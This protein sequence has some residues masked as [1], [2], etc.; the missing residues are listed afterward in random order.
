MKSEYLKR[1]KVDSKGRLHGELIMIEILQ[2]MTSENKTERKTA[3]GII[4]TDTDHARSDYVMFKSV[5]AIVL[6]VGQGYYDSESGKDI[7]LERKPGNVVWVSDRSLAYC[8]TVPG[9]DEAIPSKRIAL[10]TEGEVKKSWDSL[11]DYLSD[12]ALLNG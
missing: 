1:F 10:T 11:D 9:I 3:G 12:R 8:T 2:D 7:P 6:E 5:L 4:M